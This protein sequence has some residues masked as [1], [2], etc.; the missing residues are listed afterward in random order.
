MSIFNIDNLARVPFTAETMAEW[1]NWTKDNPSSIGRINGW[2]EFSDSQIN[3]SNVSEE[4]LDDIIDN[5]LTYIYYYVKLGINQL[6]L[7]KFQ[8]EISTIVFGV[9]SKNWK[10]EEA[11]KV[12]NY[13]VK[14]FENRGFEVTH[15]PNDSRITIG[16]Y[17]AI[18]L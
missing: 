15:N 3:L 5:V 1:E 14:E 17:K 9:T 11:E 10:T 4:T 6:Q 18:Y 12:M 7:N 16:W 8:L 13:V 2:W